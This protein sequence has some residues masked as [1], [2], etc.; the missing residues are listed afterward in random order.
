MTEITVKLAVVGT[1]FCSPKRTYSFYRMGYTS[2][3]IVCFVAILALIFTS[4]TQL[5]HVAIMSIAGCSNLALTIPVS[6]RMTRVYSAN[7][8]PD[9]VTYLPLIHFCIFLGLCLLFF[10]NGYLLYGNA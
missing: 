7:D 3:I 4:S 5:S 10:Y 6:M 9:H 2:A 1:V 8:A